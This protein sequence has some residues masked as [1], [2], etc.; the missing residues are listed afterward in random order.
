[1]ALSSLLRL[2]FFFVFVFFIIS[3]DGQCLDDQKKLLLDLKSELAFNSSTSSRLASW[4]ETVD[5]IEWDGVECDDSGRII[6]LDLYNEGISGRIGESSTLF[7][8]RYLSELDLSFNDFTTTEIPNQFHRLIN[9]RRLY[10]IMSGFVGPIP[11]TMA[12]LTELVELQLSGNF[13]TGSIPSFHTCKNLKS[14][15]L[16]DNNLIGSLSHLHFE[17]LTNLTY[18]DLSFNSLNGT[19]P[20]HIFAMPSIATLFLTG[21]K[22]GGRIDEPL[23]SNHSKM[24]HLDLSLNR[25]QGRS[26]NF[27]Q[28]ERL[29]DLG[30]SDNMFDGAFQLKN[31]Q[32]LPNLRQLDLSYNNLSVETTI[33]VSSD[34]FPRLSILRLASCNLY[35]FP[36]H[37]NLSYLSDLDLSNNHLRGDIPSW[38][39][40]SELVFL[41]LSLNL[42]TNLQKAYH[43]PPS[44]RVLD[45]HSN[46][47]RC[48]FPVLPRAT[49]I[50]EFVPNQTYVLLANNSIAGLIPTSICDTTPIA[51]L[52]L[53]FNNLSGSIPLC[54]VKNYTWL[55]VLN[56]RGNNVNGVIPDQFGE[57]CGLRTFDVSDNNLGGKIP[58]SLANCEE[59]AVMNVGNN[60]F[61]DS[62]PC[63]AL[64]VSLKILVLRSNGFRGDLTCHKSWPRLQI[65]DI[66]SNNFSG[67]LDPLNF[68]SW[69]GMMLRSHEHLRPN[70]SASDIQSTDSVY[71]D[72]VTLTVKGIEVKLVKIWPDFTSIDASSNRFQGEI[73]DAI[74]DLSSLYL[75]N[76]SHNSLTHA[77]PKSFGALTEL[78]SLDLSSNKLT[79]RIPEELAKLTFLSVM[80]VSRNRLTGMIPTGPQ[81]QTFSEDSFE[82]NTGL[83]GFPL[84]R[85]CNSPF[86]P[87]PS[88]SEDSEPKDEEIEWEYVFVVIGYV[89][90]LGSMGWILLCHRSFR[91]RYF[92]KIEEV[93]DK[94]FYE[95][96]RRRRHERRVRRREER[97]NG[98]RRHH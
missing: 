90:G 15:D 27:F 96:G 66:S 97:R 57:L 86:G 55:Q 78:G 62:F 74:G 79:G 70:R 24:V 12:N 65:F 9:L 43:I 73:P 10:M 49:P 60:K 29:V 92:E 68:S 20:L 67:T 25:L 11:S 63:M 16:A 13:L 80:N 75:L 71:R 45:L 89:V 87:G 93:V 72:E 39:W 30:L 32:S 6:S 33:N 23:V 35:D 36:N 7:K 17:A 50:D 69:S 37:G 51:V 46:R 59:L 88:P 91:E 95:R 42:L 64:P 41:N 4:N 52:D 26:P 53:S 54:L 31:I 8:L 83:C 48:E 18:L 94:I 81:L 2:L 56:L 77:I 3:V 85:S 61:H 5:S 47:L 1:M 40:G 34:G 58:K 14:I 84:E 98:L 22:F 82:G 76:L 38:I 21:N 44:L 19:I 28:L